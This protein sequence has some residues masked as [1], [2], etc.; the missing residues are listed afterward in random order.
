MDNRVVAR[1]L[2]HHGFTLG[3]IVHAAVEICRATG[4]IP[5]EEMDRRTL[6]AADKVWRVSISGS[7][8]GKPAILR[9]E[10]LR[11]ETDEETMRRAFREQ[12]RYAV[13]RCRPPHTYAHAPFDAE[14][15]YAW[16]ID[17]AV[18]GTPLYASDLFPSLAAKEFFDFYRALRQTVFYPFWP[19]KELWQR[20][21][22]FSQYQ[23]LTWLDI[24]KA[25]YS[26]NLTKMSETLAWVKREWYQGEQRCG[27]PPL[28]F[29]HGHLC[30]SDVRR[31]DDGTYK[32]GTYVVFA[33]HYWSWRQPG[34]DVAFAAWHQWM[35]LPPA[36]RTPLDV[37]TVSEN[38]L[39][40]AA[41]NRDLVDPAQVR[42]MLFNR[43]YGSLMLDIPARLANGEDVTAVEALR[44]SLIA[45]AKRLITRPA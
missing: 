34:Y 23:L 16:S 11:L 26:D 29:Q 35:S 30:G 17:E 38:W 12:Y 4:F 8:E 5:G 14:R 28:R 22:A 43:I 40:Q 19:P 33:N 21:I 25:K 20:S 7:F 42:S 31:V 13:P 1:T 41:R 9:L 6:Y 18:G 27:N 36:R 2:S 3:A 32:E 10:N 37:C 45:E 24:G 44:A 15:G 39:C